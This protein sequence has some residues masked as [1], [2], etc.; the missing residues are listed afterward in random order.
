MGLRVQGLG[1]VD[2]GSD[3]KGLLGSRVWVSGVEFRVS[4]F[5][6]RDQGL[7]FRTC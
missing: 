7:G 5:G 4:G 2:N 1:P 3:A 6:I